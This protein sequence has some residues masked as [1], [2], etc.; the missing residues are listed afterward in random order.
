MRNTTL[1][2]IE[3]NN[4]YLM[5]HRTKK[6]ND[7]SHGKWLGIGGKF[8]DKESP[9]E[10]LL[11]EVYEETGLKLTSYRLRGI[12]TFISDI[13][14]TE[15]MFLYTADKYEGRLNTDSD[16]SMTP[17]V[18]GIKKPCDEGVLR[19]IDIDLVPTLELW[20]GDRIFLEKLRTSSEFFTLKLCYEGDKLVS[21]E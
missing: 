16:G 8:E 18:N 3:E 7:Q 15:Y 13:W 2:Y 10:C 11:R 9:D 14:E 5:L 19:W 6:A 17:V 12:V 1:C 20:E 4:K 21:F